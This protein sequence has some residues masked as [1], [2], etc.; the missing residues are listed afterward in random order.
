[1]D[2]PTGQ[3]AL[4]IAYVSVLTGS[5][6]TSLTVRIRQ[7][8]TTAGALIGQPF[9]IPAVASTA[10]QGGFAAA[11]DSTQAYPAGQTYCVTVQQ[12]AATGNGTM[13]SVVMDY[14]PVSAIPG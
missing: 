13:Q 2:Q 10:N 4:L 1:M 11:I 7:G 6:T 5:G 8:T 14:A 3:G 12:G 9:A